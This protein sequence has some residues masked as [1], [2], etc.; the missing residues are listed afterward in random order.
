MVP[1]EDVFH[2]VYPEAE[3]LG[4]GLRGEISELIDLVVDDWLLTAPVVAFGEEREDHVGLGDVALFGQVGDGLDGLSV[5]AAGIAVDVRLS[6]RDG[7]F[8]GGPGTV[9]AVGQ[10]TAEQASDRPGIVGGRVLA[11]R[12][13][14]R[15]LL[16]VGN[17]NADHLQHNFGPFNAI[18]PSRD[19]YIIILKKY[20]EKSA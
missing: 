8:L 16:L 2:G 7:D 9:D 18:N 19:N 6:G 3:A 17:H 12:L 20:L 14:H 1:F 13:V 15:L 5:Q 4:D 10:E 11:D